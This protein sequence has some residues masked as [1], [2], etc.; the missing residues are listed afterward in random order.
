MPA[1]HRALADKKWFTVLK[2]HTTVH[3]NSL[4]VVVRTGGLPDDPHGQ[5]HD[6]ADNTQTM[7]A[8]QL[9]C[10]TVCM[11]VHTRRTTWVCYTVCSGSNR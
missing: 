3:C 10:E 11:N 1:L 6:S 9:G 4:L 2:K 8:G 7:D 5:R